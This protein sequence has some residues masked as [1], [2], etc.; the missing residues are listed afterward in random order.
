[1]NQTKAI[2]CYGDSN[3]WGAKPRREFDFAERYDYSSRWTGNLQQ[4]LGQG[5]NIIEEGLR[6][7]T[8]AYT[9]PKYLD[10]KNGLEYLLTCLNSHYPLDMVILFLG[11]NDLK[12]RLSLG[13]NDIKIGIRKIIS[14]I[15]QTRCGHNKTVPKII[16]LSP[17]KILSCQGLYTDFKGG[18]R[19]SELLT[20]VILNLS[21]EN[22][23]YFINLEKILNV[24]NVD[25]IHFDRVNHQRLARH[26]AIVISN[27]L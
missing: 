2:L 11:T 15:H 17:P 16:L 26:L 6:G 12:P 22:D 5:Y 18:E 27:M 4:L 14:L 1:M 10:C 19:N 24:S 3:T 25:G 13:I 7:R 8:T 21:R 23:C 9:D 20:N